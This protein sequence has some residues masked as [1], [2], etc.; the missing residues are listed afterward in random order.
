MTNSYSRITVRSR[1]L[2]LSRLV[3]VWEWTILAVVALI[4][5]LRLFGVSVALRESSH[6]RSPGIAMVHTH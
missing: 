2:A 5:C 6:S 4:L 3:A 1:S